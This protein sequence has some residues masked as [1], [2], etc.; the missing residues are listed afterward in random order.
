MV[1]VVAVNFVVFVA[2]II[3]VVVA[4]NVVVVQL[5]VTD[6]ITFRCGQ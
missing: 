6:H 2:D 1:V 3:V 4:D 5:V